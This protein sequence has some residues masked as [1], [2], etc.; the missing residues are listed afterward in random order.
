MK[1]EVLKRNRTMKLSLL[2]IIA[3]IFGFIAEALI[4]YDPIQAESPP[5]TTIEPILDYVENIDS[6]SGYASAD[7]ARTIFYVE[8]RLNRSDDGFYWNGSDW[9]SGDIW[10]NASAIDGSFDTRN[11]SWTINRTTT[12]PLPTWL[13]DSRYCLES[14]AVDNVS[15]SD[16]SPASESFTIGRIGW[17]T[18]ESNTGDDLYGIW[19]NNRSNILAV[20]G[21][22]AY[23]TYIIENF[24][25]STWNTSNLGPGFKL[26]DIWGSSDSD[27]FTVGTA[28]TIL[29]Y[30]GSLWNTMDGGTT[31]RLNGIWGSNSSNV[32]AVGTPG[33]ILR[34]NGSEWNAMDSS[35]TDVLSDIWG[36]S[37]SDIFAVGSD[38]FDYT[39][40]ILH[41][42]GGSWSVMNTIPFTSRY[43]LYSVWGSN[44]SDVY[45]V[46]TY[47]NESAGTLDGMIL[48]YNGSEWSWMTIM[49][50]PV[51]NTVWGTSSSNVFVGGED[52]TILHYSGTS[53]V[54]SNTGILNDM[55]AFTGDTYDIYAV[56]TKGTILHYSAYPDYSV[57]LDG[58]ELVEVAS[59]FSVIV[60][61]SRINNLF[62]GN[63][64]I[65]YDPSILN[66]ISPTVS[67]GLLY[68][69]TTYQVLTEGNWSLNGPGGPGS[70]G[71]ITVNF[72]LLNCD[73][74]IGTSE[75]SLAEI[76]FNAIDSATTNLSFVPVSNI[77][78]YSLTEILIG[79]YNT[80]ILVHETIPPAITDLTCSAINYSSVHLNW[81]ATGTGGGEYEIRFRPD[82]E[83]TDSNWGYESTKPCTGVPV[84]NASPSPESFDV[85]GLDDNTPYYFA[86]KVADTVPYFSNLSNSPGCKTPLL[87]YSV[88]IDKNPTEGGETEG[89]GIYPHDTLVPI[90]AIPSACYHF[91]NWS[92]NSSCSIA[93]TNS[94][95][96]YITMFDNCSL[97]ANFAFDGS[98]YLN[99]STIGNGSIS[100]NQSQYIPC[101]DSGTQVTAIPDSCNYFVNWSDDSTENPRT[102]IAYAANITYTA[103]FAYNGS[104]YLNYS[105]IGNGS[106]SGNQSQFISCGH[107][108]T[109]VSAIPD[110][111]N[112]FINWSDGNSSNPRIDTD[113]QS[114]KLFTAN[115]APIETT[116]FLNISTSG[117]GS[118]TAPGE[119]PN[120]PYACGTTVALTAVADTGNSFVNWTGDTDSLDNTNAASTTIV[121][122]SSK[123]IQAN[124]VFAPWDVNGDGYVNV[125]DI[126][127]VCGHWDQTGSPGWIPEDVRID[128]IINVQDIQIICG[129]WT[130]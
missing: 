92:D 117:N 126:Q 82:E 91:V 116:Y 96:T 75:G 7:I 1:L 40:T 94:P 58:P 56:G 125:Q 44:S 49:K 51:L 87:N 99:Y 65:E 20:G 71:K 45:A 59:N 106:I 35:T 13:Q 14:R 21:E 54:P 100:G 19:L 24:N 110:S 36:N 122:N 72:S 80:S 37:S 76:Y 15:V 70:Q 115:F 18:M 102:D 47:W 89:S 68:G 67:N 4:N 42:N 6:I 103:N 111:C 105:T 120:G 41:Y 74:P 97:K 22:E 98:Y 5:E 9:Q 112:Y 66:V 127:L 27:I 26:N 121:M 88:T 62:T 61:I 53:W 3:V 63:L 77:Y 78:D 55:Q 16:P 69:N 129:H 123:N 101:G 95:D 50:S 107:N 23:L 64:T 52:G 34:Y 93:D 86:I 33:C 73:N 43:A 2:L 128:G 48:H 8:I 30:N 114:T 31:D 32:F 60:G 79:W 118:V 109:W 90:S 84:P 28:G 25:G 85:T 104:Y 12:N 57:Y 124:F 81:T 10:I 11:E 113:I 130:G 119:G 46:G 38:P 108:G 29:H 17:E 83:I 39:G